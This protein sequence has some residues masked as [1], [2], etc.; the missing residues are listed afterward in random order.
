MSQ[1]RQSIDILDATGLSCPL[2]VLRA[3]KHLNSIQAG[4]RLTVLATDPAS[5]R[6]F[7]RFCESTSHR[8]IEVTEEAGVFR[9]VIEKG[10]DRNSVQE[11]GGPS[12]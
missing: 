8:L 10:P 12:L 2:P 7:P 1:E 5:A 4:A 6:D 9:F 3:R 11:S